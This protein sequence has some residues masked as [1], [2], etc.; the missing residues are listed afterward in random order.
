MNKI[1]GI[2][3]EVVSSV[4]KF[5]T[6]K[7]NGET[8]DEFTLSHFRTD[9]IQDV[10][11]LSRLLFFGVGG[12]VTHSQY[13]ELVDLYIE[14]QKYHWRLKGK[15]SA[16]SAYFKF[17]KTLT[18]WCMSCK[19]SHLECFTTE[20]TEKEFKA[21]CNEKGIVFDAFEKEEVKDV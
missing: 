1:K 8:I 18:E 12:R 2:T 4:H 16:D 21:I 15:G 10:C 14:P 13:Q 3:I 9:V 19:R 17:H 20:F 11:T 6:I 7:Y 5:Y